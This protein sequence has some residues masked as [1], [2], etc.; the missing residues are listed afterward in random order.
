MIFHLLFMMLI[1]YAYTLYWGKQS[2]YIHPYTWFVI[3]AAISSMLLPHPCCYLIYAATSSPV[4]IIT[5]YV[6]V[7]SCICVSHLTWGSQHMSVCARIYVCRIMLMIMCVLTYMR[8]HTGICCDDYVMSIN[9]MW[10]TYMWAHTWSS[11]WWDTQTVCARIYACHQLLVLVLWW[12]QPLLH[13]TYICKSYVYIY[14]YRYIWHTCIC[15]PTV[16]WRIMMRVPALTHYW[17]M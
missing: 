2:C 7:C 9:M 11:A 6:C 12:Y 14:T 1:V 15:V 5:A 4:L 3:Y 8:A 13:I 10:H 16:A 17:H